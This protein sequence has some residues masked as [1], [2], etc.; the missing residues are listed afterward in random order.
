MN[1]FY[2]PNIQQGVL[3]LD[4][5]ESRHA[6]KVLRMVVNDTLFLT[7][8]RGMMY[9]GRITQSTIK[10]CQFEIIA[11]RT[12]AAL[13]YTI[14]IA[15]APTKNMDR[16]EWFVEKATEMGI[17]EISFIQCRSSERKVLK[18]DRLEKI[19]ISAMKQSQ[20]AWL[21]QI[22]PM[23]PFQKILSAPADQKFI[24]YVD[25][26]NQVHLKSLIRPKKKYLVPIGPEG[27]FTND[28]L[29]I[30]IANDFNKVSLGLNR[31]RTETAGLTACQILH[32]AQL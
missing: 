10:K 29:E 28:E 22:H 11:K 3:T 9:T 31:L 14:H 12:I 30:A 26:S 18:I 21:P 19:A 1:L 6:L 17:H 15:I 20:Q 23:V 2:Q 32:F 5:E 8:G 25:G 13:D 27:D 24:G 16:I 7:D 4:E